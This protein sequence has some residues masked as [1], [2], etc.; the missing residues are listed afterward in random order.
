MLTY[1]NSTLTGYMYQESNKLHERVNVLV[2]MKRYDVAEKELREHLKTFPDDAHAHTFLAWCMML[3]VQQSKTSNRKKLK[4]IISEAETGVALAPEWD[5]GYY[6]LAW[7]VDSLGN[8]RKAIKIIDKAIELSPEDAWYHYERGYAYYRLN[9]YN[10]ARIS[11]Q[12]ALKFD[13]EHYD[14]LRLL[15]HIESET[16]R[17]ELAIQYADAAIHISPEDSNVFAAKGF[18]MIGVRTHDEVFRVFMEAIRLDPNN[19]WA[20]R[21]LKY[22]QSDLWF[23]PQ[24]WVRL[25]MNFL[26]IPAWLRF[27]FLPVCVLFILCAVGSDQI[28][29]PLAI[30][31][32]LL[33]GLF[34]ILA[35]LTLLTEPITIIFPYSY[36]GRAKQAGCN[37]FFVLFA[38]GIWCEVILISFIA[39]LAG[40]LAAG[41]ESKVS[42]WVLCAIFFGCPMMNFSGLSILLF[43]SKRLRKLSVAVL[44]LTILS[45]VLGAFVSCYFAS[46][47]IPLL[48]VYILAA[49]RVLKMEL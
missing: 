26:S 41:S 33:A 2:D 16:G 32:S 34:G 9:K 28:F 17:K 44:L 46:V 45:L 19:V 21:G 39:M 42:G 8:H 48:L 22:V 12:R 7:C 20:K 15:A 13:P 3:S 24:I 49:S 11:F 23:L 4:E 1:Q 35:F 25:K 18:A 36:L 30:F 38:T 37:E 47:C 31:F 10:K 14:S 43:E 29:T 40:C 6:I 5:Y 27:L